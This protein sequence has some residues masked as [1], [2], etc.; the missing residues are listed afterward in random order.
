LGNPKEGE[1]VISDYNLIE[2]FKRKNEK[3][4]VPLISD[5]ALMMDTT[6]AK[7][8]GKAKAFI[9]SVEFLE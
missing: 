9:K 6:K 2:A 5:V 7:K 4:E 3:D 8:Q 1:A